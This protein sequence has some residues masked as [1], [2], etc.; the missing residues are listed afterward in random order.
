MVSK[1]GCETGEVQSWDLEDPYFKAKSKEEFKERT[2]MGEFWFKDFDT[3]PLLR[4]SSNSLNQF[5]IGLS[6]TPLPPSMAS[7]AARLFWS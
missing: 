7:R 1:E 5:F 6:V 4:P 3:F 2:E